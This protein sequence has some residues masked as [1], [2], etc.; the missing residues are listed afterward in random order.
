MGHL[1][2]LQCAAFLLSLLFSRFACAANLPNSIVLSYQATAK[3]ESASIAHLAT[4]SYDPSTLATQL[5]SWTPPSPDSKSTTPEPTSPQLLRILLPNGSS[6]ITSL[7]TFNE[8]LTQHIALQL[9]PANGEVLSAC[10]TATMPPGW[11]RKSKKSK[12]KSKTPKPKPKSKKSPKATSSNEQ[13]QKYPGVHISISPP[14]YGPRPKLLDRKPPVVGVDGKEV[15][16]EGQPPEKSFF[17]KYWWVFAAVSLLA[18]V[19]GGDK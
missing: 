5:T 1:N 14:A 19:G 13:D 18:L 2:S 10:V 11:G 3:S 8:S 7:G 9:G 12:S 17:Q 15:P 6:T 4:V 16:E